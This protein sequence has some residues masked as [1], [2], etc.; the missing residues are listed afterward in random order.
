MRRKPQL[1]V[2][3]AELTAASVE[4][5]LLRTWMM[6][7]GTCSSAEYGRMVREKLLAAR[8]SCQAASGI[9]VDP[10]T[11]LRPWHTGATGNVRR[12][13]RRAARVNQAKR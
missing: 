8:K 11:I 4:T 10:V 5:V 7:S 3:L 13:R 1:P 12:L 9:V 6:A 2:L